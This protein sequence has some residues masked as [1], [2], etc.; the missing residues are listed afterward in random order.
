MCLYR[1]DSL[2]AGRSG[3]RILVGGRD[4][5]HPSRRPWGPPSLLY[6]GYRVF[7]GDK[8]A[9]AWRWPPTPYNAEVKERVEPYLYCPSGLSWL[10]IGWALPLPYCF[11]TSIRHTTFTSVRDCLFNIFAATL[12]IVG[13]SSNRKLRT[14]HAVVTGTHLSHESGDNYTMGSLTHCGRVTQIC[15]FNT[16][17][18]GTSARSP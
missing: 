15:V 8:T 9:G 17:N 6:N 10:V 4:F 16:V 12:H 7:P 14:R 3:D 1:S 5:S 11:I 2:R 18:L 13:H